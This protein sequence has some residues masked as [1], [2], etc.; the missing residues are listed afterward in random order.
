[1]AQVQ[2]NI[3]LKV[4][5]HGNGH[6]ENTLKFER[7]TLGLA[8]QDYT[9]Y[10][11]YTGDTSYLTKGYNSGCTQFFITAEDCSE[12]FDGYYCAFGKVIEGMEIVDKIKSVET[13]TETDEQTGET[14]SSTTPV[15]PPVIKSMTVDTFG[16]KYNEPVKITNN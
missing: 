9:I 1:M 14:S 5:F 2:L 6:K 11:Y 8:R 4:N 15:N 16:I 10:Y 12:N 7:G 3:L 13:T